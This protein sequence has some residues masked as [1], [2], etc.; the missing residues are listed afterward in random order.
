MPGSWQ[1]AAASSGLCSIGSGPSLNIVLTATNRRLRLRFIRLIDSIIVLICHESPYKSRVQPGAVCVCKNAPACIRHAALAGSSG[2]ASLQAYARYC[3]SWLTAPGLSQ[4]R[5]RP[6]GPLRR[7]FS[8]L[9]GIVGSRAQQIYYWF[10]CRNAN[11]MNIRIVEV[12][13]T[14][15]FIAL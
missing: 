2:G 7:V 1:A 5:A 3:W 4:V 10:P 8:N 11:C 15:T 13:G 6:A 14:D 9:P 12:G